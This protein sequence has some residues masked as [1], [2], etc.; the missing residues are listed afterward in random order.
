MWV[1]WIPSHSV[2]HL[3]VWYDCIEQNRIEDNSDSVEAL[4]ASIHLG[5]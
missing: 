2:L 4:L 1:V 5:L 3:I